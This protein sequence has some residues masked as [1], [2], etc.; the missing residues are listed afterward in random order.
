MQEKTIYINKKINPKGLKKDQYDVIIIGAGIGG[1]VCGCYLA[2][3]GLKVLI[4]EQHNKPGGYC[5]S[6]ERD[7][8]I[9]DAGA[10][11][12]LREGSIF[13]QIINDLDIEEKIKIYRT[14]PSI[15]LIMP[16]YKIKIKNNTWET[17]ADLQDKFP[18]ES[19]QIYNFFDFIFNTKFPI[20]Y[21]KIKNKIFSQFIEEYF[22]DKK[23]KA[24]IKALVAQIGV[25]STKLSTLT[26]AIHLREFV[27]DSGYYTRGGLQ[28]FSNALAEKFKEYG[29]NLLFSNLVNKIKIIK[30]EAKGV[31][32]NNKINISSKYIVSNA[33]ATQ[34]FLSLV[35][36][37]KLKKDFVIK[38]KNAIPS[39]SVIAVYLGID[40]NLK[41]ELDNCYELI[42]VPT[43]EEDNPWEEGRLEKTPLAGNLYCY[44]TSLKDSNLAPKDKESISVGLFTPLIREDYWDSN[45]EKIS[46]N[47]INR[48]E[49]VIPGISKKI[50]KKEIATPLTFRKYTLNRDGAIRGWAAFLSQIDQDMMPQKTPIKNL[51]LAGHWVSLTSGEYGL[52]TAAYTGFKAAKIILN[53]IEK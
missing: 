44:L 4:V 20:L 29:G 34:T 18:H 46:Q 2:K 37:N 23:L 39:I 36:E 49:E 7:G 15:I 19:K 27:F 42:Y 45:K 52:P 8:F 35:G 12:N 51:F 25:P 32:L 3:A 1:L 17:I 40:K 10:I 22:S 5:T 21:I 6:F 30:Y 16:D 28:T 38:L 13:R 47:M 14:D 11:E 53:R 26:A 33:D 9:F 24:I 31:V 43:Y 50:I 48:I 41:N